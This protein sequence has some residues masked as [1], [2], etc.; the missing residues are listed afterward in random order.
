[1]PSSGLQS[2]E[3]LIVEWD[4]TN[5]GTAAAAGSFYDQ[6]TIT[7]TT[8][9]QQLA[10][11]VVHYNATTLGNLA[12]GASAPEQYAFR[13]PDGLAGVGSIQFTVTSDEYNAVSTPQGEPN[14]T[15]SVTEP[16]TLAPY[17]D[18][19]VQNLAVSPGTIVSGSTIEVTWDDANTGNAAV[20]G[21]YSDNVTIV[22][23]TTGATLLNTDVAYGPTQRGYAPIAA[24]GS[25]P[26]AYSFTLPQGTPGVGNLTVT[27]TADVNN[28]VV[29]YNSSG[30]AVTNN[31]A[32]L[33]VQ[34]ALAAY[35]N[36]CPATV[37]A[38]GDGR[39][40]TAAY[41]RVDAH[42]QR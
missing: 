27:V 39:A 38:A 25:W 30:T 31:T 20:T 15:A 41:R 17:P 3:N 40:G 29:E 18:L 11:S 14:K 33:S 12:A 2:G 10:S 23:D 32:T 6:V 22:N 26:Q 28:Q 7:N 24:G 37:T 42:Q 1:M 5:T 9:G 16:S 36:W 35:P 21:P 13:L 19:Q 8:T 34:S 4:D